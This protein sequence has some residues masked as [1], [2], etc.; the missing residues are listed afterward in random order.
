M[1]VFETKNMVQGKQ[2]LHSSGD[3]QY[4]DFVR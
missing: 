1:G 4:L 2:W 3:L